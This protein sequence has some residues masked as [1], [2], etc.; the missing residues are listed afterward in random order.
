MCYPTLYTV[1]DT[2][3]IHQP[4]NESISKKTPQ[5]LWT[6][7]M[8]PDDL[9]HT[10]LGPQIR[11]SPG[12]DRGHRA[13]TWTQGGPTSSSSVPSLRPSWLIAQKNYPC[14]NIGFLLSPSGIKLAHCA[15][16]TSVGATNSGGGEGSSL[17]LA[18]RRPLHCPPVAPVARVRLGQ[19]LPAWLLPQIRDCRLAQG[20]PRPPLLFHHTHPVGPC[21]DRAHRRGAVRCDAP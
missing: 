7:V 21:S 4:S 12:Q 6:T 16:P 5:G 14:L 19:S 13:P 9:L 3:L 2:P 17:K 15:H 8:G 11:S 20:D 10:N 18:A 1:P